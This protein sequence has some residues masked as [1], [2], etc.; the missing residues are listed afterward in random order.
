[1]KF[2]ANLGFLWRELDLPDAIRAAKK[3]GFSDVECHWPYDTPAKQV[4][5]ALKETG[6]TMLGLNTHP[7]DLDD[8]DFGLCALPDRMDEGRA[9]IDQAVAYANATGTKCI[10]VMAGKAKG[11]E[12][13]KAF[14]SNLKYACERAAA[15]GITILIEP[16]NTYDVPGYF[17]T[18]TTEAQRIIDM[19]DEP[20]IKIMFDC[21]HMQLM[22]G[23]LTNTLRDLLP[24]IGHIQIASVPDRAQPDHGELDYRYV[25]QLIAELGYSAPIGAEYKPTTPTD[26]TLGWL[27][28][29]L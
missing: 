4:R 9:A 10:H 7:G 14:V 5:E 25:L 23:D 3:A 29:Y 19:V 17:L 11:A 28:N 26:Q 16:L 20:N 15:F 18:S 2:S 12:A 6:M 8:G 21:Y 1:M 24:K 22:Q 13:A 27:K